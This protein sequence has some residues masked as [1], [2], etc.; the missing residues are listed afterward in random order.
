LDP[1]IK[2]YLSFSCKVSAVQGASKAAYDVAS[3]AMAP[4]GAILIYSLVVTKAEALKFFRIDVRLN[5][6]SS[7]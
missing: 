5:L 7:C 4:T 2:S 1:L 6:T 3:K